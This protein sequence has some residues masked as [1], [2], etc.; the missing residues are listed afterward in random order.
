MNRNAFSFSLFTSCRGIKH[1]LFICL[2]VCLHT[3]KNGICLLL[4]WF[5]ISTLILRGRRGESKGVVFFFSLEKL[6]LERKSQKRSEWVK[7]AVFLFPP[8]TFSEKKNTLGISSITIFTKNRIIRCKFVI[9]RNSK[10][11]VTNFGLF[12]DFCQNF[13][14]FRIFG[15][16][17][18]FRM[19]R[20]K[21]TANLQKEWVSGVSNFS[22]EKKIRHLWWDCHMCA[23]A[24]LRYR[25][26]IFKHI[27][28][29][30]D[31]I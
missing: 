20:K 7:C 16:Y 23:S 2:H 13:W 3:L 8:P 27:L 28:F 21:N 14:N 25:I 17:F 10:S 31:P 4:L 5:T 12:W 18:F 6:I 1:N 11:I 22:A 26:S 9:F 24:Q 29:K 19:W 15:L 30:F